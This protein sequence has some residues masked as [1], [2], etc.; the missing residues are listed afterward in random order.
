MVST[1]S[2][3]SHLHASGRATW[4]KRMVLARRRGKQ[5]VWVLGAAGPLRSSPCGLLMM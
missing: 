1:D 3:L 4:Q 5:R 2:F